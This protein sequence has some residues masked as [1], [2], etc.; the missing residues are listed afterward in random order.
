MA[1]N[2]RY[3]NYFVYIN[4]DGLIGLEILYEQ[5]RV[6]RKLIWI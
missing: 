6:I 3:E 2:V 5:F 1:L 4:F